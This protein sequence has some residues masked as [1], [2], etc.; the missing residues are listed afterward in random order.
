MAGD[1]SWAL[2][3]AD[4]K[5]ASGKTT[6]RFRRMPNLFTMAA[7]MEGCTV[8]AV[9]LPDGWEGRADSSEVARRVSAVVGEPVTLEP[10]AAVPHL[11]DGSVHVL[12]TASLRWLGAQVADAVIDPVRFRPNVLIEVPG[13]GLAE[14]EWLGSLLHVGA[15][16]LRVEKRTERCVMTT[17]PQG[18]LRAAPSI[19][20]RLEEA[21]DLC[22][23]V[24]GIPVT[25][26][27]VIVG[28]RVT[29]TP[30]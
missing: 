22:L 25:T 9:R 16:T 3:G 23:G 10:E 13:E 30:A 28:D 19:L 14:E 11:D 24:Y 8:P 21:N 17:L 7:A 20:R 4:G 5:F 15:V 2:V 6:R 26:G 27:T 18:D 29:V 12:T 1:R